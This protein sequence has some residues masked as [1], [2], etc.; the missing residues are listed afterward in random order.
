VSN[1]K[2]FAPGQDAII[3]NLEAA[4]EDAKDGKLKFLLIAAVCQDDKGRLYS[5][6]GFSGQIKHMVMCLGEIELEKYTV[7]ASLDTLL[8]AVEI[9]N[10][11]GS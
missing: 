5:T 3:A 4:L 8:D 11:P 1:V 7:L 6:G 10:P 9:E 2:Y